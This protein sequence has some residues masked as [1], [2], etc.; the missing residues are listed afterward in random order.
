MNDRIVIN[1][2]GMIF[3]TREETLHRFPDTLLGNPSKRKRYY[4]PETK[5]Y[6]FNRHRVVFESILYFYQS[7]GRLVLPQDVPFKVFSDEVM[8][9]RLGEK[10]LY[11]VVRYL[12]KEK[13]RSTCTEPQSG[14]QKRIW[15]LMERP[16]TSNL[17]RA[18]SA[19]SVLMILI[20]VL[21]SCIETLPELQEKYHPRKRH[22]CRND[23]NQSD[24]ETNRTVNC[25]STNEFQN[26]KE[27][28]VV[29]ETVC[30]TWFLFEYLLRLLCAPDR[31]EFLKSWL[32]FV[33]LLAICPFFILITVGN[34]RLRTLSIL[35]LTRLMRVFRIFKLS[36]YSRGLQILG[37]TIKASLK[38]LEMVL[39]FMFIIVIISS[40]AVYYAH[41]EDSNTMF[42]SI[43][44]AFWWSVITVTTVGYG[45]V[46]PVSWS[47]Q[48]VGSVCA[49]LGVLVLSLPIIA[50][51]TNFKACLKCEPV[52]KQEWRKKKSSDWKKDPSR[53][54]RSSVF[55]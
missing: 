30:Y 35:R 5:E 6:F 54:R 16:D 14:L 9:F 32:N 21:V 55:L 4:N 15:N 53:R 27:V 7:G 2:S 8:F 11:S 49:V 19:F 12:Y 25:S 51:A 38:E 20:S 17:A 24:K 1:V 52:L 40:S 39:L 10:A 42:N 28:F 46:Y 13:K 47:G 29:L 37:T 31:M 44:E 41:F 26:E 43:P 18:I 3:E 34:H 45:D 48:I 22:S 33:D 50:F 36:R 23:S